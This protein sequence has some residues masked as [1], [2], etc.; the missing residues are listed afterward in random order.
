MGSQ[1]V[2]GFQGYTGSKGDPGEAAAIGYTGSAG[3]T[4]SNGVT[5][6]INLTDAPN[7]YSGAANKIVVVNTAAN[8]LIFVSANTISG[9][10]FGNADGG[11][12]SSIYGGTTPVDGGGV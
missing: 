9:G 11:D 2:I 10:A 1:G 12:P 8:G 4:G 7:S 6:F 5:A 3:F